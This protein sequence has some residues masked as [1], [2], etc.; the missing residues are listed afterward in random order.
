MIPFLLLKKWSAMDMGFYGPP[1]LAHY[2][3]KGVL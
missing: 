3:T 1:A 2:I